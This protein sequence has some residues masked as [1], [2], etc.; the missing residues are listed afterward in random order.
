[1][2]HV[3]D[4]LTQHK[5]AGITGEEKLQELRDA[6]TETREILRSEAY[7]GSPPPTT[8]AAPVTPAASRPVTPQRASPAAA[9]A[10][11]SPPAAAASPKASPGSA[12]EGA[13][14]DIF[15]RCSALVQAHAHSSLSGNDLMALREH[16]GAALRIVEVQIDNGGLFEDA[17]SVG[18]DPST[19]PAAPAA[20][21]SASP[22]PPDAS[23]VQQPPVPAS[24]GGIPSVGGV[25]QDMG[26]GSRPAT[27]EPESGEAS[28]DAR[29]GPAPREE[30]KG[31]TDGSLGDYEKKV[32][33]KALGY[34]L[35][36]KGGKGYGRGRCKG[37]EAENLVATLAELTEIL[38][39]E[40]VEN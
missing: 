22:P 39:D 19:E 35:K 3:M 15:R 1:M 11:P 2:M 16:L 9:A 37:I 5:T 36:H 34:L 17:W 8:T 21:E 23:S 6:L 12:P 40:M 38:H 18:G 33:T 13:A 26:V 31:W 29:L 32:A 30:S 24:A 20:A 10:A 28:V 25:L 4:L 14:K 7:G 27:F